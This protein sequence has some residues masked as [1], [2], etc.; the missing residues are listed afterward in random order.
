MNEM[1]LNAVNVVAQEGGRLRDDWHFDWPRAV[2]QAIYRLRLSLHPESLPVFVAVVGGAS[3]GKSTVFNNLLDGHLASRITARGHATLGPIL[4]AHEHHRTLIESL[5]ADDVLMP[6]F[7]RESIELDANV[8]GRTDALSI[9]FHTV[10]TLRDALLFDTP[11]FTSEAAWKEG[12]ITLSLLPWF[13]RL[14]V[15]ID[16]ERWFDRQSISKIRAESARLGQ[17]RLAL[18][19]RSREDALAEDDEKALRQQADRLAA[20]TMVVLEFRRGRGFCLFP[21]GTLSKTQGFLG[22]SQHDRAGALF[23]VIAEAAN[24]TLNQNEER[25]ARLKELRGL[26]QVAIQRIVPSTWDCM[27][28]LMTPPE[29]KQLEVVS[30]MLRVQQTRSWLE[31]QTRRLRSALKRVP[32]V[33][34]MVAE[35]PRAARNEAA[36]TTDRTAIAQS[37]YEAECRRQTHDVELAVRSSAFWNEVGR[38]TGLE[39]R[40]RRFAWTPSMREKVSRVSAEFE[41]A[42][43]RWTAKVEAECQGVSAHI[44]GAVGAGAIALA[45]ILIAV[46][47][48]VAALTLVSAKGAIAGALAELGAATGAGAVLGRHMGRLATAIH[49]KLLG[50]PEFDA[51]KTATA[52][53]RELLD[54][55]ARR[56]VN[57]ALA[58][59]SALVM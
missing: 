44:H 3:S 34:A 53:F 35:S 24:R 21:P 49:E 15:V 58:E 9:L 14:V 46:P 40:E 16:H 56:Q 22:D 12:D 27:A 1:A 30:R 50:S 2:Q 20:E 25:T 4:A 32:V 23:E 28:S 6:G 42:L 38:W 7:R 8:C 10:D 19:N 39:P 59:A 26:L 31:D 45:V 41:D 36:A 47:G 51:V 13:D 29:R 52:S 55:A 43:T 33:G 18:F 48:P 57:E 54:S 37:Y 17:R 5:L 11:D